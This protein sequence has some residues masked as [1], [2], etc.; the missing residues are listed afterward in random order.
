MNAK[1]RRDGTLARV[2]GSILQLGCVVLLL[3]LVPYSLYAGFQAYVAV[4]SWTGGPPSFLAY[5]LARCVACIILVYA[6][7][8][9][10]K[11]GLRLRKGHPPGR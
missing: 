7:W 5:P 1:I 4:T 9:L 11:K 3:G 10:R 2:F 8:Q 6:L